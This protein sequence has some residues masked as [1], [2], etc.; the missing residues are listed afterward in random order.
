MTIPQT[1]GTS[2]KDGRK[3]ANQVAVRSS[4]TLDPRLQM[5]LYTS[6][7]S[8]LMRHTYFEIHNFKGIKKARL[9]LSTQPR[10]KIFTLVGLNES[11]K[12]TVLE[13]INSLGY[14][15]ES[16]DPLD[17]PGYAVADAHDLIPIAERSNFND[18]ISIEAGFDL[19][20]D[21]EKVIAE[22]LQRTLRFRLTKPIRSFSIKQRYQFVNSKLKADT[23]RFKW[24]ITLVGRG[25][26]S[27]R[28]RQ[29]TG[30]SWLAAAKYI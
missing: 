2:V 9:D 17:L 4:L 3:G 7:Q 26:G 19:D 1:E 13:A 29:I 30:D 27:R 12:T 28:E 24:T 11:G 16:L 10:G 21:D 8:I 22:H 14:K 20:P 5:S 25:K 15:S 6:F 18:L 23:T